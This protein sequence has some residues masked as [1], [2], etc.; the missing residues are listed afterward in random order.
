VPWRNCRE[1]RRSRGTEPVG[2]PDDTADAEQADLLATV[3]IGGDT[4]RHAFEPTPVP[5]SVIAELAGGAAA[6][7]AWI[8][9]ISDEP[10]K[11]A[12]AALIGDA[13]RP[14]AGRRRLSRGTGIVDPRSRRKR[15]HA[16]SRSAAGRGE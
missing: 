12:L 6:E 3:H 13:N 14:A 8:E 7:G 10:G 15:R 5:D 9:A 11:H 1:A 16:L 2:T 4:N